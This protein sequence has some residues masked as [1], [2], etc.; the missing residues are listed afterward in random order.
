MSLERPWL[1]ATLLLVPIAVG[2]YV[3]VQRRRARY[4]VLFTN[5]DVLG[6]VAARQRVWRTHL[7]AA[8]LALALAALAIAT[9]RPQLTRLAPIERATVILVVDTSRSMESQDVKPSRLAA[10]RA[11][12]RA[13]LDRVPGKLRVGLIAFSGDVSVLASPTTDRER[14]GRSLGAIGTHTTGYGG[15]AIGDALA[16]AVELARDA[17]RERE[18]A[19][20]APAPTTGVDGTVS[21][22]FLSDGRQNRGILPPAEGARLAE[23]AGLPV[24]T[25]AL[26]TNRAAQAAPDPG[27]GQG[28]GSGARYR[29]PDPATLRMIASRTGGEFFEAR[30][31]K[32][33]SSAYESLGSRLGRASRR[34]EVTFAF[35]GVAA[36]ALAAAALLSPF[37]WP[38]LPD[39]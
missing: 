33:L 5:L 35:V 32:A 1:L 21:I 18:L 4:P 38:R 37:L 17:V 15:T 23:E 27:P 36:L 12:G 19:S 14:V 3:L 31:R 7:P 9:A 13:F 25:V 16:R 2:A 28:F 24:Y 30:S 26:G 39:R 29:A 22:L 11:A 8:L 34:T 6:A 20:V 10:A